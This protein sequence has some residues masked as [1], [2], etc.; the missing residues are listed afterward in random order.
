MP[1]L[2]GTALAA[3]YRVTHLPLL[4]TT[5]LAR[6]KLDMPTYLVCIGAASAWVHRAHLRLAQ[7]GL[8]TTA[9]YRVDRSASFATTEQ[10]LA[11]LNVAS[12]CSV[13]R[14]CSETQ[15]TWMPEV[16]LSHI[17]SPCARPGVAGRPTK[18][19]AIARRA[20]RGADVWPP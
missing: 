12:V 17:T 4:S 14:A 1:A 11:V 15:P 18:A 13:A 7:Y 9:C 2:N 10:A 16:R 5:P 20:R 6:I 19:M 3:V 8:C